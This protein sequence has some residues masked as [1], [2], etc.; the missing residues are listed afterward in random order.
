MPKNSGV[1]KTW[2]RLF[3]APGKAPIYGQDTAKKYNVRGKRRLA[4]APS[5]ALAFANQD[6]L[7]DGRGEALV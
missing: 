5:D 3:F 4:Q 7:G 2:G 6:I 1:V